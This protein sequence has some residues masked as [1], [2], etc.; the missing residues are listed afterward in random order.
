MYHP[1][2]LKARGQH[3][4][5]NPHL[6]NKLECGLLSPETITNK[7]PKSTVIFYSIPT[8]FLSVI[9]KIPESECSS[10]SGTH[11]YLI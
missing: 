10:G 6:A 7:A 11:V 4:W 9:N 8:E 2:M 5:K 1:N 3:K